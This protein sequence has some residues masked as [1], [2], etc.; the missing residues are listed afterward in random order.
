[1][2]DLSQPAIEHLWPFIQILAAAIGLLVF[3]AVG[4]WRGFRWLKTQIEETAKAML[5]PIAKDVAALEKSV[6]AAH[7]R[8]SRLRNDLKLPPD[9]QD[10]YET[11]E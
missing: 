11:Q 10:D 3:T 2:P 7:R 4:L 9:H 8:T 5:A 1:M 6:R